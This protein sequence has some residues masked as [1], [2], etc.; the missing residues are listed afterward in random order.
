M[1]C[2]ECRGEGYR[3]STVTGQE[4]PCSVCLTTGELEAC[5]AYDPGVRASIFRNRRCIKCAVREND[6]A[7]RNADA[8][9]N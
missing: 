6:H 8:L 3:Y 9:R 2:D 1:Q 7:E 5:M 4:Q